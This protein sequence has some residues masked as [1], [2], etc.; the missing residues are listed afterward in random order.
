[1]TGIVPSDLARFWHFSWT[2]GSSANSLASLSENRVLVASGFADAHHLRHGS[3]LTV[4]TTNGS[5]LHLVVGGVYQAPKLT[6]SRRGRSHR[7]GQS[8]TSR[9]P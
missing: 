1:M 8:M 4:E 7:S 6:P 5:T 9:P 3:A 2:D